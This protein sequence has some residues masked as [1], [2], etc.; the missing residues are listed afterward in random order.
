MRA[1][2]ATIVFLLSLLAAM[3]QQQAGKWYFGDSLSL[4]FRQGG[5]V[6]QVNSAMFAPEG[7]AT[8]C[9]IQGNLLFYSNGRK[10]WNRNN[11]VME[12]GDTLRGEAD[13]TQ[14]VLCLPEPGESPRLWYVFTNSPN[15]YRRLSYSVVDMNAAGGL[16]AVV[17]HNLPLMQGPS[18]RLAAVS[19]CNGRDVW[20]VAHRQSNNRFYSFLLSDEG[21][22]SQ[23]VVSDLLL[24]YDL[25]GSGY[26]KASPSG[27]FMAMGMRSGNVYLALMLFDNSRGEL[28]EPVLFSV[29]ASMPYSYCYGLA[30]SHDSRYM[31]AGIGGEQYR[32]MQYDLGTLPRSDIPLTGYRVSLGNNYALQEAPDGRIYVAQVNASWLGCVLHPERGGTACDYVP[33]HLFLGEN[34]CKQGLPS[35]NQS[36]FS[37]PS[38]ANR[39]LCE[40]QEVVFRLTGS[41]PKDSVVWIPDF[42]HNQLEKYTTECDSLVFA[43]AT[44]GEYLAAALLWHCGRVDTAF[45]PISVAAAPEV[46]LGVDTV[47]F[48]GQSLLLSVGVVDS[49]FWN[50]GSTELQ[51]WIS[52]PA[53]YWVTAYNGVCSGSD[54]L[55][56]RNQVAP[57]FLPNVFT[58]D[59]NG[60]N[61]EWKPVFPAE[62]SYSV[63][64][65]DRFGALVA[66]LA[67]GMAWDG[68]CGGSPCAEGVYVWVLQRE[69]QQPVYGS[70]MVIR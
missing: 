2:S 39:S 26:L 53:T 8:A 56:I 18:E 44:E 43:F 28:S 11:V 3:G 6:A 58:P 22:A 59:G 69:A 4:D 19:H 12:G 62:T 20:V 5:V 24:P 13:V 60:S 67:N 49:C 21:V 61:D 66:E 32:I 65:F 31:Y 27:R 68:T 63:S 64:V 36:I 30:F 16:G 29:D 15:T 52:Q 41:Y 46:D 35:F 7:C 37:R 40:H 9:D 50:D 14:S 42:L 34:R 47:L 48:E 45:G 17:V 25:N 23:P 57:V 54:T 55:A 70:V 38:I 10:I 33:N 51:R 1:Q